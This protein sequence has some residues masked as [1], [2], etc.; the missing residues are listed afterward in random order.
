[1]HPFIIAV[2][3]LTRF[4]VPVN[5]EW[6][7]EKV[8]QSVLY[9]PLVGALIGLFLMLIA[10][11][12]ISMPTMLVAA[13]V[14]M[15]WVLVTGGLHLDGLADSADAWVGGHGN[16]QRSLEIMKDPAAGP[17]AVVMLVL[18]LLLKFSALNVL[19]ANASLVA[20]IV[21]PVMGRLSSVVLFLS[22]PYVRE[23]GLGSPI[24]E[25]FSNKMAYMVIGLTLVCLFFLLSIKVFLWVVL[26]CSITLLFMRHLMMRRLEGMTG[27]TIGATV[28]IMEV[29]SLIILAI[30]I[31][32]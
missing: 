29:V 9:Y 4:P 23:K 17:M 26:G 12:M 8:A 19:L 2:Q 27:D 15:L 28:E 24:A 13:I 32:S 22:T 18:V 7:P 1:M 31:A 20:L 6:L 30:L 21:A 5:G 25:Y 14:L 3:F 11:L 10:Q 16:K